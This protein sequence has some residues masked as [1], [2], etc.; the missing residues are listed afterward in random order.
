MGGGGDGGYEKKQAE[1][2]A[3]KQEARD[4]LNLMFGVAPTGGKAPTKSD[5]TT[6]IP[7]TSG[8]QTGSPN[9]QYDFSGS[10]GP[11]TKFDRAGYDAAMA[12]FRGKAA[13]ATKNKAARDALYDKAR[14]DA[15]TA[16]SRG[17]GEK[18][19]AAQRNLKFALFAQ[20]LNGGSVDVDENALLNR[21][22]S[23]G[24]L[25]LG[26][27]ADA[28]RTDLQGNDEQTRLG[29]LQSIDAGMDQNSALS[30]A[31]NQLKIN[32]DR[33]A[34]TAQG[35]NLGDLFAD[36]GLLYTKSEAARGRQA[37]QGYAVQNLYPTT[38]RAGGSRGAGGV[39]TP[40]N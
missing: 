32:S 27:K 3:K 16:G 17:L 26:A 35:T 28:V 13:D 25:D 22:N 1:I 30:S 34:S 40:V 33:A 19:D 15:F 29:L 9:L 8:L 18:R 21:T 12:E 4:A 7:G 20:G 23:Q 10:T 14:T 24:I 39:I 6:T 5:F 36:A 11:T 31:L 37:G 2:E 38:P